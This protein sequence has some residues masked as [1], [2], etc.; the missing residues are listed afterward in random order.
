MNTG[1]TSRCC[2]HLLLESR[3]DGTTVGRFG[4]ESP[5]VNEFEL[6]CVRV[7][8]CVEIMVQAPNKK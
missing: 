3:I 4:T 1:A 8:V 5:K 6:G 2:A 7:A